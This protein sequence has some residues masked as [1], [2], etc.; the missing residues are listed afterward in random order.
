[1]GKRL[2][3]TSRGSAGASF[4]RSFWQSGSGPGGADRRGATIKVSS[5]NDRFLLPS[6]RRA[7]ARVNQL[8]EDGKTQPEIAELTGV[9]LST[10]NRAHMAYDNGG[11]NALRPKKKGSKGRACNRGAKAAWVAES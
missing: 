6:S 1:M 5:T 4:G 2:T 7:P 9:S 3:Q 10:V 11:V 8:R